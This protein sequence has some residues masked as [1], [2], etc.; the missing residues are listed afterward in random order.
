MTPRHR[1]IHSTMTAVDK[2][3]SMDCVAYNVFNGRRIRTLTVVDIFSRECVAIK[4]GQGLCG[5]DVVAVM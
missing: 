3:R 2:C 4:V 5:D 1:R